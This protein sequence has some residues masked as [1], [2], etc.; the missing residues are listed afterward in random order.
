MKTVSVPPFQC[1]WLL[2][3]FLALWHWPQM[4]AQMLTVSGGNRCYCHIS[5]LGRRP[6]GLVH[7]VS[8]SFCTPALSRGGRALPCPAVRRFYEKRM[9]SFLHVV[10]VF[11][12]TIVSSLLSV[13]PLALFSF[14]FNP[15]YSHF[16]FHFFFESCVIQSL[17]M[18]K[19][20][21]RL[22]FIDFYFNTND[23]E[24]FV[25]LESFKII[26]DVFYA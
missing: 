19:M 6:L 26:W 13:T 9:W 24:E 22:S 15:K 21:Q 8:R 5:D 23:K 2:F 16:L 4:P 12:E 1:G 14:P 18:R 17:N 3:L 20:F 7:Y 11:T 25:W 10:S